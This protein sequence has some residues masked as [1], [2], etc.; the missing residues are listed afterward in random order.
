LDYKNGKQTTCNQ[1]KGDY[2]SL[3]TLNRLSS[4]PKYH[5]PRLLPISGENATDVISTNDISLEEIYTRYA[6]H[7]SSRGVVISAIHNPVV[8]F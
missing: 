5:A 1:I 2:A 3:C 8:I 4:L 7:R 6:T